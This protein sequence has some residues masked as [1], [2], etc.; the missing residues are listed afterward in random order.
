[1][2]KSRQS[3][4][5]L[6]IIFFFCG[7]GGGGGGGW[8]ICKFG[9]NLCFTTDLLIGQII[10]HSKGNNLLQPRDSTVGNPVWEWA[11]SQGL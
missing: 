4:F 6:F 5:N 2:K 10:T 11:V 1:M 8:H 7:G 3:I 9:A